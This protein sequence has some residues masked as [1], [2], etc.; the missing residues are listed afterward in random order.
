MD[1]LDSGLKIFE[2][3]RVLWRQWLDPGVF[4]LMGLG[5]LFIWRLLCGY[6]CR[7]FKLSHLNHI[8]LM[9]TLVLGLALYGLTNFV[10]TVSTDYARRE[11][12]AITAEADLDEIWWL[13]GFMWLSP[14]ALIIVAFQSTEQALMH[15]HHMG[16]ARWSSSHMWRHDRAILIIAV[17]LVFG[18]M[19]LNSVV[20]IYQ[21]A[22]GE[23]YY[24]K[25]TGTWDEKK[26]AAINLKNGYVFVA[27]VYEAWAF[28][29]F[30]M[31][32]LEL[33]ENCLQRERHFNHDAPTLF[34]AMSDLMWLGPW[35]FIMVC[36]FQAGVSLFKQLTGHLSDDEF[37]DTISRFEVAGFV[38][39]GAAMYNLHVVESRFSEQ[40]KAFYPMTKFL[41]VNILV[42]LAFMQRFIIAVLQK[43]NTLQPEFLRSLVAKFPFFGD[44]LNFSE[45]QMALFY[46]TLMTYECLLASS[47]HSWAWDASEAWYFE[48]DELPEED[49]PLL[50]HPALEDE[51]S[52]KL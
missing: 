6:G 5:G 26:S 40:L 48:S 46:P 35:L 34:K 17:P 11:E 3:L 41:S 16:R 23:D 28:F 42:S 47:L 37:M 49:T 52:E 38:A 32:V 27:D 8:F 12:K 51:M 14:V 29:Q 22:I 15:M 31:L 2:R 1:T 4:L 39:S 24:G 13:R 7:C 30:G 9:Y 50:R 43:M 19:M 25:L 10:D 36:L 45:V 33:V 18:V 20:P 44:I 21:L